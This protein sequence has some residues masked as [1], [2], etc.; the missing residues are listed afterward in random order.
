MKKFKINPPSPNLSLTTPL[1]VLLCC[2]TGAKYGNVIDVFFGFEFN[3]NS[4]NL[5]LRL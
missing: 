1:W 5:L 4:Y 3:D 2:V